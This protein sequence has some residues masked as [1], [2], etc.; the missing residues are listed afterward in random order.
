M[1]ATP[2][3]HSPVAAFLSNAA[4]RLAAIAAVCMIFGAKALENEQRVAA[5]SNAK[6][7]AGQTAGA[8]K[9]A[10]SLSAGDQTSDL[11]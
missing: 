2:S 6:E 11:N 10:I 9:L 4:L 5:A 1:Q 8:T 3:A 7:T